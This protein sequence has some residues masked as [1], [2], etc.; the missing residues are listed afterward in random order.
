MKKIILLLLTITIILTPI[1]SM[2]INIPGYEGGIQNESRYKEVIFVTG[3][4]IEMEGTLTIK[5]N[6]KGDIRTE[7]YTYKLDNLKERATLTRNIKITA[8][9]E[10]GGN[11]VT[12]TRSLDTYRENINVGGKRYSVGRNDYQWNEGTVIQETSLLDYYAGDISARKIYEVDGGQEIVVVSTIGKSVGYDSP[13]SA[14][15]TQTIDYTIEN[16]DKLNSKNN[17]QGIAKVEASYN[18][19]KDYDFE[20]NIPHQISFKRGTVLTEKHDNVLKY[21]YDLQD[22]KSKKRNVGKNSFSMDTN[23]II[24]RLNIPAARDILGHRYEDELFLLASMNGLPLNSNYIGVETYISRGDFAKAI[25]KS[26]DIPVEKV[27]E[28]KSGR[29]KKE[30]PIP[31]MFKDMNKNHRNF[32]YVEVVGKKGIMLG[33]DKFNFKPDE[34]LTRVEAYTTIIRQLGF[35]NLA[36]RSKNYTTGYKDDKAIPA[37]AKD[38]IYIAKDLGMTEQGDYFYPHRPITKGEAAKLIVDFINYMQRDLKKDYR[39]N[40]ID[41]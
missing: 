15:E 33:K 7:T 13:W 29:R 41:M 39:G 22:S 38:Y 40:V 30:K 18:K 26:M 17:S 27:E 11:Q 6:E 24:T 9:L 2:A 35:E 20:D 3:K 28:P 14:T 1:S 4:P 8:N 34:S 5:V 23:P 31:P 25:V 16:L 37:W 36:P 19:T 32:D 10:P 12:V 21:N